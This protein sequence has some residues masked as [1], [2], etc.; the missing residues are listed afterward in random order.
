MSTK[1]EELAAHILSVQALTLGLMMR[2]GEKGILTPDDFSAIVN[3]AIDLTHVDDALIATLA[4]EK[5]KSLFPTP[6]RP[7]PPKP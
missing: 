2:L 1:D 6:R 7:E 3:R 4:E 5:L